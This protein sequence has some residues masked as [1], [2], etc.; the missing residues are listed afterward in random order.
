LIFAVVMHPAGIVQRIFLIPG[1]PV[2]GRMSY[3]FYLVHECANRLFVIWFR[4]HT[5][6][7]EFVRWTL[8]LALGVGA[9]RL[10]ERPAQ[11][12]LN[13]FRAPALAVAGGQGL[14]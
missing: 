13:S 3:S 10:V 9:Y 6:T 12:W 8:T 1:L 14:G 2:L 11:A 4:E 7:G 5:W